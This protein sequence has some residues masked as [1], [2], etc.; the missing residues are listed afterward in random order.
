M[1]HFRIDDHVEIISTSYD[2]EERKFYGSLAKVIDIKKSQN[3]KWTDTDL[4]LLFNDGYE[5]WLAAEDC[6]SH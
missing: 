4:R 6:V 1:S 2:T 5:T 3:G